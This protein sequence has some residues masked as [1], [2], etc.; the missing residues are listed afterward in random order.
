MRFN[1]DCLVAVLFR[2]PVNCNVTLI[3]KIIYAD[4]GLADL[5]GFCLPGKPLGRMIKYDTLTKILSQRIS[6]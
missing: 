1:S 6:F 2:L 5:C 4:S 3:V